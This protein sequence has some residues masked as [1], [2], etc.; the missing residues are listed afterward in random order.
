MSSASMKYYEELIHSTVGDLVTA[1]KQRINETVDLSTW[2][3]FFGY[4]ISILML[5]MVA[6]GIVVRFDFMGRMAWVL[7][8]VPDL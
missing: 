6:Y 5:I 3:T 2:M 1:F 8:L 4:Y 7:V